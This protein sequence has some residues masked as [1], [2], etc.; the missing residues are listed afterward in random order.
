M[1]GLSA[2]NHVEVY[3]IRRLKLAKTIKYV[4]TWQTAIKVSIAVFI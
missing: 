2:A 1:N 3:V 4:H